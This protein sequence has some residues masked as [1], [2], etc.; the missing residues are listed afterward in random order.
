MRTHQLRMK[1]ANRAKHHQNQTA[2]VGRITR[3]NDRSQGFEDTLE[4][5]EILAASLGE[6]VLASS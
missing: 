2:G 4:G 6:D 3:C 1:A 5:L